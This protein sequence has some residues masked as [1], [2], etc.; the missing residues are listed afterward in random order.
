MKENVDFGR[1][2]LVKQ[3]I[4]IGKSLHDK[5]VQEEIALIIKI[6]ISHPD[7]RGVILQ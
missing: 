5:I 3:V 6:N 4:S 7:L 1:I 2:C